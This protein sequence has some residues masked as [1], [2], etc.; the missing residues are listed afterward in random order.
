MMYP[1][2]GGQSEPD[3]QADYD[4]LN[5]MKHKPNRPLCFLKVYAQS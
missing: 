2:G 4:Q 1:Y 3:K 5:G